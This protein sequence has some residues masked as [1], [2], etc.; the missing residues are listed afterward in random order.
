LQR[1]HIAGVNKQIAYNLEKKFG[2]L[3]SL[4]K[5]MPADLENK[6][7]TKIE[8]IGKEIA[9]SIV[10]FFA[11]QHNNDVIDKLLARIEIQYKKRRKSSS[12][13]FSGKTVVITGTLESYTRDELKTILTELGAKITGSV[14]KKT[15]FVIVGENPGAKYAHAKELGISIIDE[16]RL[17]DMLGFQT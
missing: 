15:D 6:T 5:A 13:L 11:E 2:D 17:K 16:S 3:S 8:G 12:S 1:F 10:N 14:S 4:R 7:I 9:S